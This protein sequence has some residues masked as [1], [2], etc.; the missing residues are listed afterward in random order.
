MRT[1]IVPGAVIACAFGVVAMTLSLPS[2]ENTVSSCAAAKT[3]HRRSAKPDPAAAWVGQTV[4]IDTVDHG[5]Y[6]G[7][8]ESI[9]ADMLILDIT[10]PSRT[11]RYSLP[12]SAV[13]NLRPLEP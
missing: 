8:L 4:R 6:I 7:T 12:R 3:Q 11:L 9:A 2:R 1:G 10:L 13:A 5:L